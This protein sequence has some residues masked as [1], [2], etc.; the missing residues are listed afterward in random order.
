MGNLPKFFTIFVKDEDECIRVLGNFFQ[1][2]GTW[3]DGST[4]YRDT[5]ATTL[6]V[7]M[8]GSVDNP[9][10]SVCN[11]PPLGELTISGSDFLKID[12]INVINIE[13]MGAQV[14]DDLDMY[15]EVAERLLA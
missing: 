14:D 9:K 1:M 15:L 7:Q 12:P 8:R 13:N 6:L 5:N 10:I 4:E 2:S 11:R 3:W